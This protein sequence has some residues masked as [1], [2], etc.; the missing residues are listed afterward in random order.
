MGTGDTGTR[1]PAAHGATSTKVAWRRCCSQPSLPACCCSLG[2]R[3]H[4]PPNL[5]LKV[6]RLSSSGALG[7]SSGPRVWLL[8]ALPF[9]RAAHTRGL[10][11]VPD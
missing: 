5:L 9:Q 8:P 7:T 11:P 2:R 3:N 10:A 6:L 4:F 1:L